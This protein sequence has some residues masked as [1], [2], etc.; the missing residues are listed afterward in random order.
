MQQKLINNSTHERVNEIEAQFQRSDLYPSLGIFLLWYIT[1]NISP[2]LFIPISILSLLSFFR[3]QMYA[4]VLFSVILMS[5]FSDSR[6]PSFFF[7][8]DYKNLY[9]ILT[10]FLILSKSDLLTKR[11]SDFIAPF[12]LFFLIAFLALLNSPTFVTGLLKTISYALVLIVIPG[13]VWLVENDNRKNFGVKFIWLNFFFILLSLFLYLTR[14]TQI[15]FEGSEGRFRGHLGN[16]NGFGLYVL[17]LFL[18]VAFSY[19][20]KWLSKREFII[21]LVISIFSIYLTGSRNSLFSIV[22]FFILLWA[23][24][25]SISLSIVL[26]ILG[27]FVYDYLIT[28]SVQIFDIF[29]LEQTV[30]IDTLLT[31]GGRFFAYDFAWGQI[32]ESYWFGN[33]FNY[34]E[35]L[36]NKYEEYLARNN[37]VGNLHNSFLTLWLDTGLVGVLLFLIGWGIVLRKLPNKLIIYPIF[38]TAMFSAYFESWL[39]GSQNPYT[40]LLL[41]ILALGYASKS[42]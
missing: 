19:Y 20:Q 10:F 7:T 41:A 37:S 36:V 1:A 40:P 2:I 28:F 23:F 32:Q 31:G 33:G 8:R 29:N 39:A 18:F 11:L 25:K 22:L 12:F 34:T 30:R 4:E 27:I 42:K 35:F 5:I 14:I 24:K 38:F 21:F 6:E 3:K 15:V 13:I 16:P 17:L 26:I 9:F